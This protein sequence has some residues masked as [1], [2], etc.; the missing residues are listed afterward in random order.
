MRFH[1]LPYALLILLLGVLPEVAN[2]QN[3]FQNPRS[4]VRSPQVLGTGDATVA[5]PTRETVFFYNPAHLTDVASARPRVTIIGLQGAVSTTI[6]RQVD[7]YNDRLDPAITRGFENLSDAELQSL[8]DDA[9]EV[10]RRRAFV[11]GDA[12]LPSIMVAA[13]P[14]AMG[15]GLFGHSSGTYR[16]SDSGF[17]V[18]EVDFAGR[19]DAMGVLSGALDAAAVGFDGLS[20][21]MTAKYTRRYLSVKNR[22]IDT[23]N[24]DEPLLVFVGN[25]V[26]IDGGLQYTLDL[27]LPGTLALGLTLYD[28]QASAY[29]FTLDD[30]LTGEAPVDA[31][32][33]PRVLEE[34]ADIE[35]RYQPRTS[36]R[37]GAAYMLPRALG[38][39]GATGIMIDYVGYNDPVI[40]QAT[41]S[42]LHVGLQ[43]ELL[44]IVSL[45]T[46][47]S[48]GYPSAGAGLSL[49]PVKLDYAF[50]AQEEGRLPGQTPGW[51]HLLNARI[52]L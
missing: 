24:E 14:L 32:T 5:F 43:T 51:Q 49:G 10:G 20:I 41:L 6:F 26:S 42:G 37:V 15:A 8:Y 7:F 45:R 18:P 1:P 28:V 33:D 9:F 29:D 50:F 2:G 48:Q 52:S 25:S 4:F 23:I 21:G 27:P 34:R 19:V 44:R 13:G 35:E 12:I 39:F 36:Y 22:P 31:A 3:Y 16:F 40:E 46:G 11:S 38:L 47:L 30:V 17:G